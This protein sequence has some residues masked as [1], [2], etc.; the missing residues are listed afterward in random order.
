MHVTASS[1]LWLAEAV[2]AE[3]GGWVTTPACPGYAG[4]RSLAEVISHAV[5]PY[6]RFPPSL[7]HGD[8]LL[9]AYG[10]TVSQETVCRR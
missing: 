3:Q 2:R 10:V 9:A 5:W 8:E 7:R 4:H 1:G 6:S